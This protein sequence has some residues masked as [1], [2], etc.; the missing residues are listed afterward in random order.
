MRCDKCNVD[1]PET[2]TRCPLC[3]EKPV[4]GEVKIKGLTA[5]PYSEESVPEAKE[6]KKE[7]TDFTFEKIKAFFNL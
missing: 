7:K 2:Y 1:L 3:G 4:E 5:V 6:S